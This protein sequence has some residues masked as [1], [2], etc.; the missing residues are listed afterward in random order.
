MPAVPVD[1]PRS[2]W[3]A[4]WI[5]LSPEPDAPVAKPASAD[6]DPA[7]ALARVSTAKLDVLL[8]VHRHRL[9]RED[10]EDCFSQA[11]LELITRANARA[12]T[13][14]RGAHR[15]RA[16]VADQRRA[17]STR[18]LRYGAGWVFCPGL[19]T[20]VQYRLAPDA[21]GQRRIGR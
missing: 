19:I 16:R 8:A 20:S 10:L 18:V 2:E 3:A 12:S 6:G 15:E 5:A 14:G 13:R 4:P 9:V 11:T 17:A 21:S 7:E 1:A